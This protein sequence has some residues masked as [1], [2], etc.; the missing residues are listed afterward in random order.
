MVKVTSFLSNK[1]SSPTS[2]REV[3][4]GNPSCLHG[5]GCIRNIIFPRLSSLGEVWL[6]AIIVFIRGCQ[7]IL[8]KECNDHVLQVTL[9]S[10][11]NTINA[12]SLCIVLF[13]VMLSCLRRIV[14]LRLGL[15][16]IPTQKFDII[17][18]T[19]PR[20]DTECFLV[21]ECVAH[22]YVVLDRE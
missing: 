22:C 4:L 14:F 3:Q 5:E 11:G 19:F 15:H 10:L 13:I 7:L 17:L 2:P 8:A 9:I 20:N 21:K 1:L 12:L 16:I 18:I 6:G